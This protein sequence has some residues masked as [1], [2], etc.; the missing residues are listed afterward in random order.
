[1]MLIAVRHD[2]NN[3][4]NSEVVPEL[5]L[6]I[7]RALYILPQQGPSIFYIFNTLPS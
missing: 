2:V 4:E 7:K 5:E 1:M 3:F 6:A